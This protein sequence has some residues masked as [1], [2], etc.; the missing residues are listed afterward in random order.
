MVYSLV[1][2][3][4]VS[5]AFKK[6]DRFDKS[7]YR[8]IGILPVISKIFERFLFYQINN[9]M[10]PYLSIYQCGFRKHKCSKL[11]P[12]YDRELEKLS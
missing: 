10:D 6:G 1:K 3:A 11:L 8:A 5:P 12:I 2:Y 7:N 4:D 9:Y